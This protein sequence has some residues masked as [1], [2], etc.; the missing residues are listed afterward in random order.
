VDDASVIRRQFQDI[1]NELNI[2]CDVASDGLEACRM[3]EEHGEYDI[4]FIDWIM[5]GMDGVELTKQ[6]KSRNNSK[7]SVAIMITA[8]NWE[9]IKEEAV[10]A[11]VD[12]HLLKPLF[13]STIID[14]VNECFGNSHAHIEEA[15]YITGE[16]AGKRLL[17]AE[18]VEINRE[19]LIAL[20][21]DTGIIIDCAENGQEAL[22]MVESSAG[23]YDI[24]F[25]DVQMPIMDGYAATRAIRALP[26]MQDVRLP[27]I[28]M[29][30]NVFK[31]DI[32]ESFA[33]GMDEH[34]RKPIDF[35]R[36]LKVLRRYL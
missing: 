16:F 25:M 10:S 22:E 3:I 35:D 15:E 19:I 31:S 4:Y 27:I 5:P 13:T 1:F 33:A 6:I 26:S 30:A 21:E 9:Q 14:C 12:K 8:M 18:D 23:K 17:L 34:L 11:G 32:E 2:K 29:T 20:L 28:A 36:V 24:V 7:P